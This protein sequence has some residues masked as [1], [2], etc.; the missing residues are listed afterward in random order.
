G[1]GSAGGVLA[2]RLSEDGRYKILCL[3]AGEKGANYIWTVPPGG[4]VYLID[5]PVAN[6]RYQSEPHE[7]HGNR[8]IYV[9]RGKLLGGSSALNGIIYNRGQ[10][11]DYDTW[12]QRGCPGW[13]YADVLPYFK[14]I[15]STDIGSDEYRGRKGPV[16]VNVMA[17]LSPFY[18]L[19]IE[20]AKAVGIPYN[21][22]YSGAS[23]EG[24]AMAQQ[25]AARGM[26]H[27]TATQYLQPA[28]RRSNLTIAQ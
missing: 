2:S 25:T 21:T 24:I 9:P 6:W 28:R 23:Q 19:Y 10:R 12:A 20:A 4:V 26:R 27:S 18:D 8:P 17:K 13:S 3:E 15:E 22:D 16:K 7:S 14:R 5:N 1:S 11:I